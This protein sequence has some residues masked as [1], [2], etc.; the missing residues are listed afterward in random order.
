MVFL[1]S[2]V[3]TSKARRHFYALN[4]L[5]SR[6]QSMRPKS[7]FFPPPNMKVMSR[8][9]FKVSCDQTKSTWLTEDLGFTNCTRSPG[10][11][12][13]VSSSLTR[14]TGSDP[15][16]TRWVWSTAGN[17]ISHLSP[18]PSSTSRFPDPNG[19]TCTLSIHSSQLCKQRQFKERV[20]L[21]SLFGRAFENYLIG[22]HSQP[23]HFHSCCLFVLLKGPRCHGTYLHFSFVALSCGRSPLCESADIISLY[24]ADFMVGFGL[25]FTL[26]GCSLRKWL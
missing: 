5:N 23:L 11:A 3:C 22:I 2:S 13:S 12:K 14:L 7:Q 1:Q 6:T 4:L 15:G 21:L 26:R 9:C 19:E 20:C 17:R 24:T 10:R 8:D 18:A 16:A 25:C